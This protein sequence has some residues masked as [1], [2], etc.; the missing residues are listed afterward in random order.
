MKVQSP[1]PLKPHLFFFLSSS[2]ASQSLSLV[3]LHLILSFLFRNFYFL[4][5]NLSFWGLLR[6]IFYVCSMSSSSHSHPGIQG[7]CN[8]SKVHH[9]NLFPFKS[10]FISSSCGSTS[11]WFSAHCYKKLSKLHLDISSR[12]SC[13]QYRS[14][15]CLKSFRLCLIL[16]SQLNNRETSG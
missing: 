4:A 2:L 3:K 1:L 11:V 10:I 7:N 16:N 6:A 14:Q 5:L 8:L 13:V 9:N 12:A 15:V